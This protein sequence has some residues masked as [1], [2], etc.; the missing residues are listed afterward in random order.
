MNR[1]LSVDAYRPIQ[2][3]PVWFSQSRARQQQQQVVTTHELTMFSMSGIYNPDETLD[4][5]ISLE[6]GVSR[7]FH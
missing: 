6:V 3:R 7:L 4:W 2:N 1:V 5:Q